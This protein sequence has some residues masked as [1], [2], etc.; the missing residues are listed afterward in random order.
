MKVNAYVYVVKDGYPVR[1]SPGDTVPE[2]VVV[3]NPDV[4][5]DEPA[6]PE[7]EPEKAPEKAPARKP[8]APKE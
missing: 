5:V 3:T 6:Q 8:A 7:K 2:G 1:L 4:L